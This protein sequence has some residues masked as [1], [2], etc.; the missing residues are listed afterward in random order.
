MNRVQHGPTIVWAHMVEVPHTHL[1]QI[2]LTWCWS[3][4]GY[5]NALAKGALRL[6]YKPGRINSYQDLNSEPHDSKAMP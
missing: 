4:H 6:E 2:S 5:G 3:T 1:Y